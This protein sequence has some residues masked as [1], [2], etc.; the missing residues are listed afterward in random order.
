MG[1][2]GGGVF[3]AIKG[4]RN[5]PVVSSWPV[6]GAVGVVGAGLPTWRAFLKNCRESQA[7]A[8]VHPLCASPSPWIWG[9]C[10]LG[11]CPFFSPLNRISLVEMCDQETFSP[12]AGPE[13]VCV[14]LKPN[15]LD[16]NSASST[17]ELSFN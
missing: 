2:I 17:C 16:S 12:P 5:A 15:S 3:Q 14:R 10:K 4:F 11:L 9:E 8:P 1:V 6:L 13:C 7:N